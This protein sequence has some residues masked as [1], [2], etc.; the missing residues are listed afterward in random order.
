MS[1]Q[2]N[3]MAMRCCI[4]HGKGLPS[5]DW[6]PLNSRTYCTTRCTFSTGAPGN[7]AVPQ[8]EDVPRT[9]AGLGEYLMHA[10]AE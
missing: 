2:Q 6:P 1:E 4:R 9:A 8:I 3:C 7:N 5:L 10:I